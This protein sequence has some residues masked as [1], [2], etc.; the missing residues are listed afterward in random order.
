M[1]TTTKYF[2][3][4]L[5]GA[6]NFELAEAPLQHNL[7]HCL[8]CQKASGSAFASNLFVKREKITITKGKDQ[9]K[10]WADCGTRSGKPLH[11]TFCGVCGSPLLGYP[12]LNPKVATVASSALDVKQW[13]PRKEGFTENK[14]SW[15]R[16]I[17]LSN[18]SSKAKL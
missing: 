14:R 2:G 1:S 12:E 9:L 11:R 7:C 15:L 13:G 5:C 10:S 18:W 3:S 8:N 4:C 6:V 17:Q 16:N